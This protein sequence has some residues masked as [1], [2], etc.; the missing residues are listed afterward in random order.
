MSATS[1]AAA[2]HP[3][4]GAPRAAPTAATSALLA[5]RDLTVRFATP[6]GEV[7]AVDR[8]ALSLA[9]GE[10]LGIVGESGS[11]KS[12]LVLA[13]LGLLAANGAATGSV[14]LDG[15]ELLGLAARELERVRGARIGL[16]FQDPMTA[17]APH[18]SIGTQLVETIRAHA[19]VTRA[20]AR[21]RAVEMLRRVRVPD[22][23]T[24]LR[25]YPHELSGG[26]R[27]R[28]MI[29]IALAAGPD[30]LIADEPTTALDVTVQRQI[31]DLFRELRRELGTAL[32]LI[33][34]DLG[35]VAGLCDHVAVM[36]A[37][38][39]VESAPA[40][41]LFRAPRH[42]YT[43]GLLAA[44]P[45]L[46]TSLDVPLAVIPGQPPDLRHRS[47]GCAYRPRCPRA[48]DACTAAP[49]L[50]IDGESAVACHVAV[51]G[52]SG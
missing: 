37:G 48:I 38:R 18:L 42:P 14:R 17:L 26:L 16:V 50:A 29:A 30:V 46:D 12:Q 24:R 44:S 1:N 2:G 21:A 13:M 4:D 51:R 5:V 31:L 23:E 9:R 11:G 39:I 10:C 20:A 33:T 28:A 34:H 49:E 41:T 45:R 47:P 25:Q 8:V 15:R 43:A 19:D 6:D 7:T 3:A 52:A 36:Y 40:A 32:V 35:V 27:Q 22:P